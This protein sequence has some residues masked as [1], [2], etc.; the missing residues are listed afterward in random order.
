MLDSEVTRIDPETPAYAPARPTSRKPAWAIEEYASMR[1][2][3]VCEIETTAPRNIVMTATMIT[4]GRQSHDEPPNAT[5]NT[6]SIASSAA[7][8]V[9][10]A[11]NA[12]TGVGA[13]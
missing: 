13:P 12:V 2:T 10:A 7:A 8:L 1:L 6:R 4:V 3:S 5:K 11:M 9:P